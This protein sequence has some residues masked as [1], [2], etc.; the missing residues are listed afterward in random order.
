MR[1]ILGPGMSLPKSSEGLGERVNLNPKED[2]E[3]SQRSNES[4]PPS[5]A[6][7]SLGDVREFQMH[8]NASPISLK[9]EISILPCR[10][11]G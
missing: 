2:S 7:H 5:T 11:R 9:L 10:L 8:F 6:R 4:R 1:R 3:I